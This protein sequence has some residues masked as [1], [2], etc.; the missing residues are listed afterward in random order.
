MMSITSGL[1]CLVLKI[2]PTD[3]HTSVLGVA[4]ISVVS[5]G[6]SSPSDAIAYVAMMI[7]LLSLR[8]KSTSFIPPT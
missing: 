1:L 7:F 8:F 6:I 4:M 5:V 2:R 3:W